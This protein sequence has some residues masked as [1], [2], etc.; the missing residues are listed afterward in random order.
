MAIAAAALPQLRKVS[1][2]TQRANV[3]NGGSQTFSFPLAFFCDSRESQPRLRPSAS[4]SL[5]EI[6]IT[7]FVDI[8]ARLKGNCACLPPGSFS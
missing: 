4:I 6:G 8:N 2:K 7:I 3:L 1:S 5:R